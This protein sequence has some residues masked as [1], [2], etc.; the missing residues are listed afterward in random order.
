MA[1]GVVNGTM[2]SSGKECGVRHTNCTFTIVH[3]VSV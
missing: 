3:W 2:I 1:G